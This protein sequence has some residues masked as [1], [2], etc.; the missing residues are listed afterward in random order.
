M[1][2]WKLIPTVILSVLFFCS[3]A[4]GAGPLLCYSFLEE[5][6]HEVFTKF[7]KQEANIDIQFL[8]LGSNILWTRVETEAKAGK[9]KSDLGII[10][11]DFAIHAI[12]KGF[13][14]PYKSGAWEKIPARFRDPGGY[15][16]GFEYWFVAVIVNN[17]IL[18]KKGLP[19]P[20]S[21]YDLTDPKYKGEIVMPNPGTSGTAYQIV[22]FV[23]Q[24]MGEEKAWEYLKELNK[25]IAQYTTSGS[26]PADL[27][28]RGEFAVGLTWELPVLEKK[29]AG[30]PIDLVIPDEGTVFGLE[31]VAIFKDTDKLNDAKKIID[32]MATRKFMELAATIHSKVT[33][34]GVKSRYEQDLKLIDYNFTWAAENKER[35]MNTWKEK[36]AK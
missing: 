13:L 6:E 8:H 7:F 15:W 3:Y 27:V 34:P 14:L 1:K 35:I 29:A 9:I 21:W 23:F 30:A 4:F 20:R 36:F 28:A 32:L 12:K 11:N 25:N 24:Y 31:S 19:V 18:K 10:Q 16:N 5:R 22:S 17:D 26:A 33:M 2:D